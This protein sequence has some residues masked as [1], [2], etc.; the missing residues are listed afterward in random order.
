MVN[1]EVV[2]PHEVSYVADDELVMGVVIN[3]EARAYPENLGWWHEIIN[4]KVGGQFISITLCPLTGTALN[5]NATDDDGSQ[6]EF[7]VSGL[8]INSNLVMYDRRDFQTL[9]PQM[10]YTGIQGT[11][12]GEQLE[13]LPIVETTWSMWQR[14]YPSTK[15]VQGATGLDRYPDAQRQRYSMDN[16]FTYP[17]GTYREDRDILLFPPPT[18]APD[19][20]IHD[21]K[22]VVFGICR[23]QGVKS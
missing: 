12:E 4:D 5:F 6:I 10:I 17:Y 14:M 21:F 9:C 20:S 2:E 23:E 1:P 18:A 7:G 11:F 19:G 22:D 3:G 15:V 16:Y 13:L 8:L